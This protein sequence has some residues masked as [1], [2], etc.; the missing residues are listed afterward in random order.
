[1]ACYLHHTMDSSRLVATAPQSSFLTWGD[2]RDD[3]RAS[4]TS[5][6]Y[7]PA[8][9]PA[10][11]APTFQYAPQ[12]D[13]VMQDMLVQQQQQQKRG[14]NEYHNPNDHMAEQGYGYAK[15]RCGGGGQ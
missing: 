11:P 15:R 4:A 12:M 7:T 13:L 2:D 9:T 3:R 10:P 14:F 5:P 6:V 1:M 8:P